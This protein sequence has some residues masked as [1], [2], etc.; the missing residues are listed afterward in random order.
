L[1]SVASGSRIHAHGA[2]EQIGVGN[3]HPTFVICLY[4][5]GSGLNF[6]NSPVINVQLDFIT[7]AKWLRPEQK[8]SREEILEYVLKSETNRDASDTENF[9]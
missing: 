4:E 8:E 9:N 5:R 3:N 2:G 6:L 1:P 7:D